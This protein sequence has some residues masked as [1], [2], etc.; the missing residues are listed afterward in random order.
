MMDRFIH[1]K[2]CSGRL[3][4]GDKDAR[5]KWINP[6][7]EAQQAVNAQNAELQRQAIQRAFAAKYNNQVKML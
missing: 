7:S 5:K 2:V 4:N 3:K 1:H 6:D